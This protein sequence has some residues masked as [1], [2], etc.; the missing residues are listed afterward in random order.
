MLLALPL[1][2]QNM[3]EN[4]ERSDFTPM[5]EARFFAKALGIDSSMDQLSHNANKVQSLSHS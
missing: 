1:D 5:E 3:V 4:D 2:V